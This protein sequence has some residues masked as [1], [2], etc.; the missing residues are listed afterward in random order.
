LAKNAYKNSRLYHYAD[1][2]EYSKDFQEVEKEVKEYA[3]Y[4]K[5]YATSTPEKKKSLLIVGTDGFIFQEK[6]YHHWR[7][8]KLSAGAFFVGSSL[9]SIPDFTEVERISNK[10]VSL[11]G[12]QHFYRIQK[13][14]SGKIKVEVI[15]IF[16]KKI[17]ELDY[18]LARKQVKDSNYKGDINKM[19][20]INHSLMKPE[21]DYRAQ[22]DILSRIDQAL[23]QKYLDM[24]NQ[25]VEEKFK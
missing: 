2:H 13:L 5:D 16:P 4:T 1:Q 25:D 24:A 23:R 9:A 6:V 14:E 17:S 18:R 11:V 22:W 15:K 19:I 10:S 3:A 21:K 8:T 20:D 7:K 12:V